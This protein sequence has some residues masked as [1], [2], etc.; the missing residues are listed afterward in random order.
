[1]DELTLFTELKPPPPDDPAGMRD[2]TRARLDPVLGAPAGSTVA[3]SEPLAGAGPDRTFRPGHR[4]GRRARLVTAAAIVAVAAGAA[5]VTTTLLPSGAGSH[6]Q[7]GH[8]QPGQSQSAHSPARADWVVQRQPSGDFTVTV[9]EMRN[10]AALQRDLRAHGIPAYVFTVPY[11]VVTMP[12]INHGHR[13]NNIEVR[14]ISNCKTRPWR[15]LPKDY[16]GPQATSEPYHLPG[17]WA[18]NI[19]PAGIPHGASVTISIGVW[20]GPTAPGGDRI[21]GVG[22]GV[23]Y[24]PVD[25]CLPGH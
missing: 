3:G 13:V 22:T 12:T 20:T 25:E 1:V 15:P 10:P 18:F 16:R 2:R 23:G 11:E 17:G 8:A 24:G 9:F 19:N 6:A 5:A 21:E 14:P 4:H 7:P